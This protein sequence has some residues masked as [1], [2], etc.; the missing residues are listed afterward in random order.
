[1]EELINKI[2]KILKVKF[3]DYTQ[4]EIEEMMSDYGEISA[5][6]LLDRMSKEFKNS[7][8]LEEFGRLFSS[9]KTTEAFQFAESKGVDITKVFEEVSKSVV[10]DV[11]S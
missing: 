6:R 4:Q 7:Q 3:P 5:I 11:F 1:M 10:M 9:T 8:E 2:E